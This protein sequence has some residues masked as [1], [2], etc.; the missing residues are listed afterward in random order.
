MA[1]EE[2]SGHAL[3]CSSGCAGQVMVLPC[4][5][6]DRRAAVPARHRGIHMAVQAGWRPAM[7]AVLS[8]A[9]DLHFLFAP[10]PIYPGCI[11]S[12]GQTVYFTVS[13][14]L[15]LMLRTSSV[16]LSAD[17]SNLD[18]LQLQRDSV[19]LVGEFIIFWVLFYIPEIWR[20]ILDQS[21]MVTFLK[22][23]GL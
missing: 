10:Q 14:S 20:N 6:W 5:N 12:Y 19:S 15:A 22:K 17:V 1:E 4:C 21:K 7:Q 3:S 18:R 11:L 16:W 2:F 13:T 9:A 23:T 8:W